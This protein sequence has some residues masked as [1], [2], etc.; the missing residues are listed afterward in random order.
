[1]LCLLYR[2]NTGDKEV[3]EIYFNM[4]NSDRRSSPINT[5]S[6]VNSGKNMRA[7]NNNSSNVIQSGQSRERSMSVPRGRRGVRGNTQ[8]PTWDVTQMCSKEDYNVLKKQIETL[9]NMVEKTMEE[10]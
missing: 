3:I 9:Y 4:S 1:M 7:E 8:Y 10:F 5:R 6:T 2:E